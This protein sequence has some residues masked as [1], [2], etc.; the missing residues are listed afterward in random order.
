MDRGSRGR[1]CAATIS[2]GPRGPATRAESPG[3][4][5]IRARWWRWGSPAPSISRRSSTWSRSPGTAG[6]SRPGDR[7]FRASGHRGRWQWEGTHRGPGMPF[8]AGGPGL[9]AQAR[10]PRPAAGAQAAPPT[11]GTASGTGA[12]APGAAAPA[13]DGKAKSG[14]TEHKAPDG[15]FYY[16]NATTKQSTWE[17]PA[18]LVAQEKAEAA[19]VSDWKE[20]TAPTGASTIII[21]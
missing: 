12:P 2:G 8:Q 6:F 14:W 19:P 7:V 4:W 16:Y 11:S 9:P 21:R 3:S 15:R 1:A 5:G 10:G 13:A 18:E 17:K 20:F